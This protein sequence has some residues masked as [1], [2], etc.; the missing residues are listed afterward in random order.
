MLPGTVTKHLLRSIL[1]AP[2][3][4]GVTRAVLR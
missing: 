3:D 1:H 4:A 2:V